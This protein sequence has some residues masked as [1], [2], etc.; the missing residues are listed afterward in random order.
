MPTLSR[1]AALTLMA[2]AA[3]PSAALTAAPAQAATLLRATGNVNVRS[4]AG[5]KFGSLGVLKKGEQVAAA[6]AKQ[7]AWQPVTFRGRTGWVSA[8]YLAAVAVAAARPAAAKTVAKPAVSTVA[9]PAVKT[10]AKPAGRTVAGTSAP[11]ARSVAMPSGVVTN[12]RRVAEAVHT[13]FPQVA[14]MLGRRRDY[15]S[16]HNSGRAVDIMIPDYKNNAAL[17]QAIAEYMRANASAFGITYVI[18]D[19]HI[20]SVQRGKEGWRRMSNRGSDNA[21]HKNHVHVSVR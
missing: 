20:W 11:I 6:G 21:N 2:L 4:G 15:D 19:Q 10:V 8:K 17:G 14:T 7:G 13:H 9:K 5:T 12:G 3:V 18:W 1:R 16:D